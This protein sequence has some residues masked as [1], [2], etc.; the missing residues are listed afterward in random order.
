VSSPI[1]P[2]IDYDVVYLIVFHEYLSEAYSN[3]A[4]RKNN[5]QKTLRIKKIDCPHCGKL[6]ETVDAK[7]KVE[8][9]RVSKK[10]VVDCHTLR[11]CRKCH[12]IVGIKYA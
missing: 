11:H 4:F 8:V 12:G 6:F 9:Y 3:V 10:S 7:T 1:E 5:S 2:T